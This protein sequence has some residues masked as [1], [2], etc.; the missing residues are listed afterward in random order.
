MGFLSFLSRKSGDRAPG[1]LIKT[2]AYDSTTAAHPPVRGTYPVTG[3]GPYVL[4]KLQQAARKRST[5][6]IASIDPSDSD[7]FA[8]LAAPSPMIPRFRDSSIGRPTSA[9]YSSRLSIRSKSVGRNSRVASPAMVLRPDNDLIQQQLTPPVPPI[10]P[11]H[12]RRRS[13]LGSTNRFID[14]LD[15]QG[16]FRPSNFR[17]RV[18]ASGAREFGED[19]ADRNMGIN[20]S[21]LSSQAVQAFY[22]SSVGSSDHWAAPAPC[23]PKAGYTNSERST[24]SRQRKR[25]TASFT[26][27]A[28]ISAWNSF[29]ECHEVDVVRHVDVVRPEY[30]RG[31]RIERRAELC[32]NTS[33]DSHSIEDR[34]R[35]FHS[36]NARSAERSRPR[37]L[38]LHPSMSNFHDDES[39]P[40]PLP[41][42][43]PRTSG[44]RSEMHGIGNLEVQSQMDEAFDEPAPFPSIPGRPRHGRN[45]SR[46]ESYDWQAQSRRGEPTLA[47]SRPSSSSSLDVSRPRA[48][49]LGGSSIL[50]QRLDDISEHIPVRTSSLGLGSQPCF[51]PTSSSSVY[52]SNAFTQPL[53]HH[54]PSTSIDASMG[55]LSEK[56]GYDLSP[57][58][59]SAGDHTPGY[60]TNPDDD[61]NLDALVISRDKRQDGPGIEEPEQRIGDSNYLS[62][63]TDDSDVDSFVGVRSPPGGEEELLFN[64]G[65]YSASGG[66]P[67]L[68]DSLQSHQ[69]PAAL[70]KSTSARP[71]SVS[72]PRVAQNKRNIS[73]PHSIQAR[74]RP[75]SHKSFESRHELNGDL[76]AFLEL[77]HEFLR[78]AGPLL[79]A[80]F[81]ADDRSHGRRSMYEFD[82]DDELDIRTTTRVKKGPKR[83]DTV[84]S[85]R[86]RRPKTAHRRRME[87]D[88][89]HAADAED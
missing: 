87:N 44:G 86:G 53:S 50:P 3:N 51:T 79:A 40:P 24:R 88:S 28:D 31:R 57:S 16:E 37:P 77:Q 56:L 80:S 5:P 43:R 63:F 58:G 25:D 13:S 64:E 33:N 6:Q 67:G 48:G 29:S 14:I 78:T 52:S 85:L 26:K 68:F 74:P 45:R 27:G 7:T 15:A 21:D 34:R 49:S 36:F 2:Q 30:P 42:S 41:R 18:D 47:L 83:A 65:I 76:D 10:P 4:D 60:Y 17:S 59:P 72:S 73:R 66:L 19:V 32:C 38:S 8:D 12:R 82:E 23:I 11:K 54:T 39:Y 22:R 1:R 20:S 35:S 62:G 9:P 55:A 69:A 81:G 71:M 75:R 84:T 61:F 89:G 70:S 46:S